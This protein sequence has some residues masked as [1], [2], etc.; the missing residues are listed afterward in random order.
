M[1]TDWWY[2]ISSAKKVVKHWGSEAWIN[3]RS[4]EEGRSHS[5]PYVLKLLEI[6]GGTRTSFQYHQEKV[7]TNYLLSGSVEAWYELDDGSIDVQILRAN[8]IWTIPAGRKHRII[9]LED[10]VLIEA[11]TPEVDDVVRLDDD[12]LRGNGRIDREHQSD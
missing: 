11:S 10:T 9:T 4:G 2:G 5:R 12:E 6:K 7:E 8:S 3:Y 1:K